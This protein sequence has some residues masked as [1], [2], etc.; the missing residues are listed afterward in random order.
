MRPWILPMLAA[1]YISSASVAHAQNRAPS[2]SPTDELQILDPQVDPEGKPRGIPNL[3]T[4]QVEIPPV[5]IVHRYYYTG[6]R[7]FQGPVLPGGPSILVLHHPRTGE[8]LTL[9]VQMLPGS[10]RICYTR[11]CIEYDYGRAKIQVHFGHEGIFG[12]V[13]APSVSYHKGNGNVPRNSAVKVKKSTVE[14]Q[15]IRNA[16]QAILGPIGGA[17][18]VLPLG[19]PISSALQQGRTARLNRKNGT[20]ISNGLEGTT[21]TSR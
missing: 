3:Q 2:V 11:E 4:G 9:P 19:T 17:F 10:P 8:Q 7:S 18:K 21:S 16:G 1:V 20:D 13:P 12:R 6:N 14:T 15:P 5:L